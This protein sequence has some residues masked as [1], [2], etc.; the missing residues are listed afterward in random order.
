M[1]QGVG[2]ETSRN[3]N[4][5]LKL[6]GIIRPKLYINSMLL[7]ENVNNSLKYAF[8]FGTW[9]HISVCQTILNF[10]TCILVLCKTTG[11]PSGVQCVIFHV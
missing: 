5:T 4:F 3:I 7:E 8:W 9:W 10:I 11:P 2:M 1:T 6:T